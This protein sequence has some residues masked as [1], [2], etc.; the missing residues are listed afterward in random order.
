MGVVADAV[1]GAGGRAIGVIT[2]ALADHEI[3]IKVSIGSMWSGQCAKPVW[4]NC[5][6]AN[7]PILNT[8][9][10]FDLLLTFMKQ[11]V[12]QGFIAPMLVEG[13]VISPDPADLVRTLLE[14]EPTESG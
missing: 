7:P 14:A 12:D 4:L 2:T 13:L 6:I 3:A 8:E 9:G 11:A 1:L 10:F 5:P